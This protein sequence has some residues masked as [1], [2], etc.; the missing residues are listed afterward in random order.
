MATLIEGVPYRRRVY[1]RH[2]LE[3]YAKQVHS[4]TK[5]IVD[6]AISG[7]NLDPA[8]PRVMDNYRISRKNMAGAISTLAKRVIDPKNLRN[9]KVEFVVEGDVIVSF[10]E[11]NDEQK[12]I[13]PFIISIKKIDQQHLGRR[14]IYTRKLPVLKY[15]PW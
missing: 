12:T 3:L 6:M 1:Q 14:A 15:S 11:I 13:T 2:V 8:T 5:G 7:F 10:D 4:I 9:F